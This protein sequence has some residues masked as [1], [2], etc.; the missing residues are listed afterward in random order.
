[1]G[2][3]PSTAST[4]TVLPCI[5]RRAAP[6][7]GRD[8]DTGERRRFPVAYGH[9]S[10]E[11]REIRAARERALA[12]AEEALARI[13]RGL[14]GRHYKTKTQ[15]DKRLARVLAPVEGLIEAKSG[16]RDGRPTLRFRRDEEAIE[17]TAATDGIT[18]LAT[19]IPGRLSAER[20]LSTYKRQWIVE[21][22]HRVL[23]QTLRVRPIFL[24]YRRP[25]RGARRHRRARPARLRPD[26]GRATQ[27]P[28]RRATARASARGTVGSSH[29]AQHPR[30]LPRPR[31]HIHPPTGIEIDRLTP[32][33]QRILELLEIEPPWPEQGSLAA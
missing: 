18:A 3:R 33:Q 28:R 19:N 23:K 24:Q 16:E 27:A 11:Q 17:R 1:L 7:R 21:R 8:P 10:E 30:R 26:R 32:T 12:K 2:G 25:H 22:R 6:V 20:V 13:E 29:R 14:G 4:L 31:P 9:S 15:V 5:P